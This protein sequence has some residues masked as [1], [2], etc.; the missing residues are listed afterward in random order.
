MNVK[1]SETKH[2]RRKGKRM[3]EIIHKVDRNFI[4]GVFITLMIALFAKALASL[5]FLSFMGQLVI[6]MLMGMGVRA[7]LGIKERYNSGITFSSKNLL[8]I[9]IVLLG[10]SLNLVDLYRAGFSVFAISFTTLTFAF[11]SIY[12]FAKM[13]GV[14]DNLSLLTACGT[15]ICGA[16]AIVAIAPQVRANQNEIAISATIIALLGTIFTLIYTFLYPVLGLTADLFGVFSGS[17]LHEVA[18][19]VAAAGAGGPDAVELAVIAKLSRVALLVPVALVIGY[20]VQKNRQHQDMKHEQKSV[21][22]PWFIIGFIV[23][24]GIN[25]LG[26]ISDTIT[27]I[28]VWMA[29]L[30]IA[31]A[32]AGLGLNVQFKYFR[33]LGLKPFVTAM[34]GS[35]L[36]SILGYALI[37]FVYL[38]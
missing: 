22:F 21:N 30:L 15:A 34:I 11:V 35:L 4:L 32:M 26:I 5:P 2:P 29:Y 3:G 17:T 12:L 7:T 1:G 24:S 18:H 20:F 10:M 14:K 38:I 9:G 25:S 23:V 33:T 13:L 8:R 28:I 37:Y 27:E 36:M 16:S 6:A 19:A 31:M